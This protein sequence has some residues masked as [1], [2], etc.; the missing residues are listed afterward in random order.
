MTRSP[1]QKKKSKLVPK[2]DLPAWILFLPGFHS[3]PLLLTG[4]EAEHVFS[5]P[6]RPPAILASSGDSVIKKLFISPC[7]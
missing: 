5:A 6:G 1:K 2:R 4:S 7:A 3:I